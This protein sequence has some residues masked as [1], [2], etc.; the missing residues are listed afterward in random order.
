[1]LTFV[2]LL[3]L[4]WLFVMTYIKCI[5]LEACRAPPLTAANSY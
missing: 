5:D 1:M 3:I 2:H 4:L